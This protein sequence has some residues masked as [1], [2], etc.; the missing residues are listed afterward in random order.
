M[1]SRWW[2]DS[3]LCKL[4]FCHHRQ[5]EY[6]FS[7]CAITV[8]PKHSAFR[9]ALAKFSTLATCID[10]IYDTYGTLDELELFTKAV[11]RWDSPSTVQLPEYLKIAYCALYDAINES[12][13][14]AD[15][16]QG[17][18]TLH[19]ARKAWDDY[20]DSM[21]REAKWLATRHIPNFQT[22]LKNGIESSAS[23]TAT[24][25]ALLTLDKISEND[26]QKVDYPSRFNDLLGLTLRLR[27]DTR[28]FK[29]EAD[30]GEVASSIACYMRDNPESSEEDAL[31]CINFMLEEHLKELNLEYLKHD[32]VPICI[33]DFA[34]D[35]SRC[36]QVFYKERDG[37]S[38]SSKDMRDHVKE[39]LIDPIKM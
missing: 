31:K 10:D 2:K 7:G 21:L 26:L 33:K 13:R 32:N 24:L 11:K 14:E 5:I 29:T 39:I 25:Q 8:E 30:R 18:D 38:I 12:A 37:F 19:Y 23:L 1:I 15:K 20:L 36:F 16:I 9:I 22:Y 3:K 17:R 28:T 35:M 34:Y 4:D 27:G 6:H